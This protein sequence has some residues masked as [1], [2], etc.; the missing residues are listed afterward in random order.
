MNTKNNKRKQ[1]SREKIKSI[2][3]ELLETKELNQIT[4]SDI[5][6][7]AEL[8]RSTFYANYEDIYALADVVRKDL[9]QSIGGLLQFDHVIG[10][11]NDGLLQLFRHISENPLFYKTYFKLGYD[12]QY[13]I[14]RYDRQLAA[15]QFESRFISYHMEFFKSGITAIIKMWLA[16]GCQESP[17]EMVSIIRSEYRGRL[18]PLTRK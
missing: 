16:N 17:E 10:S 4:V 11:L 6:T 13:E 14:V 7:L 15:E 8:N 3:M 12:N 1:Q 18:E 5:C 9:E 2:F